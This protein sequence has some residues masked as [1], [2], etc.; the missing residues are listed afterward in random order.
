[1]KEKDLDSDKLIQN[2]ALV[3]NKETE[4]DIILLLNEDLWKGDFSGERYSATKKSK[5]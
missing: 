2:D 1:M 3:F 5:R 4:K